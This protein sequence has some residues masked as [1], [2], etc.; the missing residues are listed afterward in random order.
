MNY[1][2]KRK[3]NKSRKTKRIKG[4]TL[5]VTRRDQRQ[6]F[7]GLN[8]T[9]IADAFLLNLLGAELVNPM[10]EIRL[11]DFYEYPE[12]NRRSGFT[13]SFG[14]YY[15]ELKEPDREFARNLINLIKEER[16]SDAMKFMIRSGTVPDHGHEH[17]YAVTSILKDY[18][19]IIDPLRGMQRYKSFTAYEK[20]KFKELYTSEFREL[21]GPKVLRID[22]MSKFLAIHQ[23]LNTNRFY[24]RQ[25]E[26]LVLKGSKKAPKGAALEEGE[27]EE[28]EIEEGEIEEEEIEED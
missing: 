6:F 2:T 1:R 23:D 27:I 24:E 21:L 9:G 4:G 28:E 8:N 17:V 19:N 25:D 18:I 13:K 10:R 16:V 12:D 14:E 5:R 11:I 7:V 26:K 15:L 20:K 22:L 3:R